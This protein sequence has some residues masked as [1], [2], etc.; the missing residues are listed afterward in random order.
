MWK[1][2]Y[3][4]RAFRETLLIYEPT[5]SS[6]NPGREVQNYEIRRRKHPLG[7]LN[8]GPT[9]KLETSVKRSFLYI[10]KKKLTV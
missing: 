2:T 5:P 3:D 8:Y 4:P 6:E 9:L 10:N 1:P 7:Y